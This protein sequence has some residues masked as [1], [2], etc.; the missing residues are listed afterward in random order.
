MQ[1]MRRVVALW[2]DLIGAAQAPRV[3][4]GPN[5]LERVNRRLHGT[6]LDFTSN[7]GD[8]RRIWSPSLQRKRDLYVYLPPGFDANRRYPLVIFLHGAGQD[9][10]FFLQAQVE[11]IDAAMA[12][13][14]MPP[15]IVC[16]PD[17]SMTGGASMLHPATF[18]A[19]SRAGR[20]EDYLMTD[21]WQFLFD[22]FSIR[23]ERDA[24]ALV[25]ASMGGSA[26]FAH[27]IRHRD[28]IKVAVGFH[29]PLDLRYVC[30]RGQYRT[31]FVPER[32]SVRRRFHGHEPLGRRRLFVL[33][34]GD[35]FA[36]MF[37][38]APDA[39]AAISGI[40]PAELLD[41]TDLQP[42]E[43]D[44]YVAYGGRDEFNIAAQVESFLWRARRRGI[45]VGV[46]YDPNGRHDLATS[47][48]MMPH[49]L[50]WV[51]ERARHS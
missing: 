22:R 15:A 37:G 2:V 20:F 44:L 42:G 1:S 9:E 16:A 48:R 45:D 33:R 28:R 35:L 46:C 12:A 29:P 47:E 17:G 3:F 30:R 32:A 8:D 10:E 40:N 13:G 36:P 43:L 19:N 27:A 4:L 11:Q 21:V 23:P 5:L 49:V 6:L 39:L 26:A 31:R 24:H 18:F 50:R 25:G 51:G 14:A 34:Y 7:H 41:A 38:R